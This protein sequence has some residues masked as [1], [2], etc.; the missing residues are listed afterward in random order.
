VPI[1]ASAAALAGVIELVALCEPA[2]RRQ[3]AAA[4]GDR[5]RS[6]APRA[7]GQAGTPALEAKPSNAVLVVDVKPRRRLNRQNSFAWQIGSWVGTG[8]LASRLVAEPPPTGME[9]GERDADEAAARG[10]G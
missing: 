7:S 8:L 3:S 2:F 10:P 5:S 1:S 4:E 6:E 9:E